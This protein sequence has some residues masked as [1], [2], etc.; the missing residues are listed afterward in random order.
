M[1]KTKNQIVE[2]KKNKDYLYVAVSIFIIIFCVL[3]IGRIGNAGSKLALIISFIL[4]DFS[5]TILAVVLVYSVMYALFKKKL[6]IHHIS[7]IGCVFIYIAFSMYAHLGLYEALNMNS[8]NVLGK[9]LELYKNYLIY[10][11]ETYSCGGGLIAATFVQISA[12]LLGKLGTILLGIC[13]I[14]IGLSFFANT[15]I[16]KLFKGGKISAI[17]KKVIKGIVNYVENIHYPDLEKRITS[18]KKVSINMLSDHDEQ[19][20]F[21]LQSQ[22]NKE[23][24]DDLK[25]FIR[26]N[27][28]YCSTDTFYTSY[29]SSRFVLKIMNKNDDTL[30]Q[31]SG[32]FQRNCFYLKKDNEILLETPNQFRKLLTLKSLLVTEND[33]NLLPLAI[34]VDGSSISLNMKKGRLIVAIGEATSGLRTFIRGLLVSILV[35]GMSYSDIYFYDLSDDFSVLNNTSIKYINNERSASIALDEAFNEYER[36]SEILKYLDC[37]NINDANKEIKKGN[38]DLNVILPEYHF[39]YLDLSKIN[40]SLLQKIT[41]AIRFTLKV[42]IHIIICCRSRAELLKLEL[43]N[44]DIISFYTPDVTT[45]LKLFGSDMASRLQKK[46]DVI[47]ETEG[48]IYHGQAPYISIEDFNTILK[49]I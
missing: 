47:I 9:T 26:D 39:L 23:K 48:S 38:Q 8:K 18:R 21:T 25:R 16:F 37:D 5:T 14:L 27:K 19:V 35:K 42:G 20:S 17:P 12:F 34:D 49:K 44:S 6:D 33:D 22:I 31:I 2:S 29:S 28:I 41:Y 1:A 7:F 11:E 40:S 10:Y 30:K 36:R 13:F 43:N 32:F 46:G 45:S 24:F 15:N 4:G 3:L